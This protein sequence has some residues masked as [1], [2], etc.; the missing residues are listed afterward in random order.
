MVDDQTALGLAQEGLREIESAVLRLLD[1]SPQGL[2]NAQ[3][4]RLLDL[5]SDFDGRR[6]DYLTY[7]VLGGLLAA[8]RINWD[9]D[10]KLFTSL[11]PDTTPMDSARA[12][13]RQIENGIMRLLEANPHGLRNSEIADLLHLRSAFRG[14]QHD[15]LTYSVLGGL[16]AKGQVAWDQETK[17]FTK[18]G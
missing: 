3:I 14:R 15:Y 18:P 16:L 13:L 6:S 1:A 5:R 7:S 17:L 8:G 12:G 11:H 10:T 4:A 2:R 9:E